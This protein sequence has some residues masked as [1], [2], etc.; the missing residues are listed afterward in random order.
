MHT[1]R[2]TL[3]ASAGLV[4]Q[5]SASLALAHADS[6]AYLPESHAPAG[7]MADHLHATGEWMFGYRYMREDQKGMRHGSDR[8]GAAELSAAGY[9]MMPTG[10]TM[11]MHM[12]DIMYAVSDDLTLMLMPQYMSM[13]MSMK[14]TATAMDGT[15]DTGD[16][17]GQHGMAGHDHGTSGLGDTIFGGL[18]RIADG[19]DYRLHSTLAVSV[20][21]GSVKEKNAD[22]SYVHYG[23]Q[24]GSGTWDLLPSV[25]YNGGRDRLSW[26]AQLSARLPME[27]ENEAG[28]A[29][30]EKYGATTWGAY[31]VADWLSL[32]LR[33]RYSKEGDIDG[34]YN[35]AHNHGS[36]P[37]LQANYG[38]E[39]LDYGL[40]LNLAMQ[41]GV[42]AG[43]RLGLE[44]TGKINANVNGYQLDRDDGLNLSLSYAF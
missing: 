12:L 29:F 2:K 44:W 13:D 15:G 28:F 25:T 19:Q 18:F 41:Q 43:V 27:S 32:S 8:V 36:P 11:D 9:T 37:D 23:M 24:L 38:G 34:H 31:R 40:G 3:L 14:A 33:L 4:S 6:P 35:G 5:L 20:P 21:T 39:F 26:G 10:M 22:G 1:F 7:V 30:G 42:A 17:H 16:G